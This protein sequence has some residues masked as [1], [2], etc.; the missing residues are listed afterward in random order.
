MQ[1]FIALYGFLDLVL[2]AY[3]LATQA[4]VVGGVAFLTLVLSLLTGN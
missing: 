1:A 4:I 2:R 3:L